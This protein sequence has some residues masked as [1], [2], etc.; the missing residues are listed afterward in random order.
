MKCGKVCNSEDGGHQISRGSLWG[1]TH[2]CNPEQEQ[3]AGCERLLCASVQVGLAGLA[4]QGGYEVA[5]G[6][7]AV[8]R[9]DT[10]R[11]HNQTHG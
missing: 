4:A 11:R 6:A 9:V 5:Q 2:D 1:R 8:G 10:E 3:L 7:H